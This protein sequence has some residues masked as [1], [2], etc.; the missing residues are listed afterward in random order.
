MYPETDLPKVRTKVLL[1]KIKLPETLEDKERKF[2][3]MGL[4]KDQAMQIIRSKDL[5]LFEKLIKYKV[6]PKIVA[7][8]ILN[9]KKSLER[10]GKAVAD[11]DLEWVVKLLQREKIIKKAVRDVLVNKSEKGFEKI[12]GKELENL[13]KKYQKRF[14]ENAMKELMKDYGKRVDS[15]EAKEILC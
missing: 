9:I 5:H 1:K 14:G 15:I 3:E 8:L 10:E 6:D 4:S 7:D 2:L 13:A 12:M 11:K